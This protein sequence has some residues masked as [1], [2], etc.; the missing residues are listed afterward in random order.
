MTLL[1]PDDVATLYGAYLKS[2]ADKLEDYEDFCKELRVM[3]DTLK[4]IGLIS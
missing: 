4:T 2:V 1:C 3:P